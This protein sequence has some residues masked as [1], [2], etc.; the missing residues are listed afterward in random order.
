MEGGR[1]SLAGDIPSD[2]R[3]DHWS[4]R[5]APESARPY[6]RLIRFDRP[7]GTWLLLFPCWWSLTLAAAVAGTW[8]DWRLVLLFA[9][10]ALVMRSAGCTVNDLAD[11]DYDAKVARTA[12]RPIPSG[13][14]TP[15]QALVFL[16]MELLAGL[17]VLVQLNGFAI[18]LG[19]AAL[20]LVFAYPF[21]KRFT[22]WPQ[23]WLG[24]TFNWGAL[25]GWAAVTGGLAWPP[26]LLYAAGLC[27]T[28]GYDTIYAHQDK[29]DD[30][31]IGVKSTALKLGARTRPWLAGFY[32]AAVALLAAAGFAAGLGWPFLLAV[33]AVA[34]S[35]V[36]PTRPGRPGGVS[37]RPGRR[38][39]RSAC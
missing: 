39:P 9:V 21:M 5:L 38:P 8:P 26:I 24:L 12:T 25:V 15:R 18:L 7:I 4:L 16:A 34:P 23:A 22:Y 3:G 10:G 33:A 32:G 11:R 20:P 1:N 13:Q 6:L 37:P 29:E 19:L 28:L 31:L 17:L 14:I 35:P 36:R 27:W 2:I 30:A